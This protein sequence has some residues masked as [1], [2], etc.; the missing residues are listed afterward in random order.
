MKFV[1]LKCSNCG[2]KLKI[3][4]NHLARCSSCQS[5]F[6]IDDEK[7]IV[8]NYIINNE[9][10][11]K[12]NNSS[13]MIIL[14]VFVTTIIMAIVI[15]GIVSKNTVTNNSV[16]TNIKSEAYAYREKPESEAGVAFVEQ[17]FRKK[18]DNIQPEELKKIKYISVTSDD[19]S[20]NWT[21]T[22]SFKNWS[23]PFDNFET[24]KIILS[25]DLALHALDFTSFSRLTYLDFNNTSDIEGIW[26]GFS[27]KN[28]DNLIFYGGHFNQS[29][30][31]I[32]DALPQPEK[33]KYLKVQ[34]RTDDQL[35]RLQELKKLENLDITYLAEDVS[36]E[37]MKELDHLK[38]LM[39]DCY[40]LKD[41]SWLS[42]FSKLNSLTLSNVSK[43]SDYSSLYSLANLENLSIKSG[44]KLN[45][46]DFVKNMPK[47]KRLSLDNTFVHDIKDIT[48]KETIISLQLKGNRQLNNIES[49]ASLKN[50]KSL[51]FESY[52]DNIQTTSLSNLENLTEVTVS[53]DFLE[54]IEK[55]SNIKNYPL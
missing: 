34:V 55:S 29:L 14:F 10:N 30:D 43:I 18:I 54:L 38:S 51:Q 16:N 35:H 25:T 48:D 22:Y 11:K 31:V 15:L 33:L 45:N 44:D 52:S 12:R 26:E 5:E 19:F 50:L 28:L 21:I 20:D 47:L 39:I 37:S 13:L 46:I 40:N 7:N 9:T 24:Q 53:A 32:L 23:N 41:I 4:N 8:N 2:G 49:I 27:L 36:V 17:V 1:N 3:I 6:I 42:N